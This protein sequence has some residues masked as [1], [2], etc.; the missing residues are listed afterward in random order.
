[1]AELFGTTL[2]DK[3]VTI[4]EG[5]VAP[6]IKARQSSYDAIL[7]DVYNGPEGL[8]RESNDRLDDLTGSTSARRALRPGGVLAVWSSGRDRDFSERLRIAGFQTDEIVVPRKAPAAP[9][10]NIIRVTTYAQNTDVQPVRR[11]DR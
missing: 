11:L 5:D 4:I 2:D 8:T 9:A 3:R 10:A 7:L 1:M 6:L